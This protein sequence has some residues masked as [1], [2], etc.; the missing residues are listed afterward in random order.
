MLPR[1]N[2]ESLT[3]G[4]LDPHSNSHEI[5]VL[6]VKR[7]A[8]IVLEGRTVLGAVVRQKVVLANLAGHLEPKLSVQDNYVC[9]GLGLQKRQIEAFLEGC[10]LLGRVIFR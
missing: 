1:V 2:F 9:D 4:V 5:K 3:L 7:F 8:R 10:D 6:E